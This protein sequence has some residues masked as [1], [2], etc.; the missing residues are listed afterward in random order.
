MR[1]GRIASRRPAADSA[2]GARHVPGS[3]PGHRGRSPRFEGARIRTRLTG[4]ILQA[5]VAVGIVPEHLVPKVA[6]V[7]AGA[8]ARHQG[9]RQQTCLSDHSRL[10]GWLIHPFHLRGRRTGPGAVSTGC[11]LLARLDPSCRLAECR[12]IRKRQEIRNRARARWPGRMRGWSDPTLSKLAVGNLT[13][14][15]AQPTIPVKR[16]G[17]CPGQRAP[18]CRLERLLGRGAAPDPAS[19]RPW[20][21]S[22]GR[23]RRCW[24][25]GYRCRQARGR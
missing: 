24:R 23:P 1:S 3:W 12:H 2:D 8:S 6:D 21:Q 17:G 10:R 20:R 25:D 4:R 14:P 11:A 9:R 16:K 5:P 22:P 19:L 7:K 13:R 18:P 15:R